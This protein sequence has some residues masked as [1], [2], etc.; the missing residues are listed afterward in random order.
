M[1]KRTKQEKPTGAVAKSVEKARGAREGNLPRRTIVSQPVT[2]GAHGMDSAIRKQQH[3][4]GMD[5]YKQTERERQIQRECVF[6]Y[7]RK[8]DRNGNV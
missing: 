5:K 3:R 4:V 1:R 8:I 7:V 2:L 6:V